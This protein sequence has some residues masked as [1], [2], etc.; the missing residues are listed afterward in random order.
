M[1]YRTA[2][3]WSALLVAVIVGM[4]GLPAAVWAAFLPSLKQG[5]PNPIPGYE[6]ILLGAAVFC[7]RLKWMLA[8]LA[9]P[10]VV[11]LFTVAE[12]TSQKRVSK[13]GTEKPA[14]HSQPPALW[15]PNAAAAWSL[16]F[17]PAFGA[18]LHA[19]N[20]DA[21]GRHGEAKGNRIWF[22]VTIAYF[23][24]SLVHIPAIPEILFKLAPIGLLLGW[25][26]GLGKKQTRYVK[27]TFQ[28]GYKRKP[29]TRPLITASCCLIGTVIVL[30]LVEKL[31]L[32]L[33]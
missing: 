11:V 2:A 28:D 6:R 4:F 19:R 12:F 32:R 26:F 33:R 15:N 5:L 13:V 7:S 3:T 20:A 16:L 22:Y 9:F 24:F 31:L 14:P 21:M 23:G 17:S 1:R 8:V 18:F 27:Q 29:W 25:Y 10:I 30:T